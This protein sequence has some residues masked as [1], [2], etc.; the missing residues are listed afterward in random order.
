M[1]N[2]FGG[3]MKKWLAIAT[4]IGSLTACGDSGPT[5]PT[6]PP[7]NVAASYATKITASS[8]CSANLPT[9]T[10]ALDF[11]AD[12]TQTGS[13][14]QVKLMAHVPGVPEITFSGT[15]SGQTVN[16]PSFTF[17]ETMG[18]GAALA[19]SGNANVAANGLSI[20]GTLN[21]TY[22]TSSGAS[23]NAANHQIQLVKLCLTPTATGT[24]MLPC[25]Q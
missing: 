4:A 11:L 20:T 21:G 17:T 13:A 15:V 5:G 1:H 25:Q 14:V 8:T 12:I 7:A 23:C 22:Q 2:W 9:E 18:R 19:A 10:R 6:A 16:F 3:T 24:A